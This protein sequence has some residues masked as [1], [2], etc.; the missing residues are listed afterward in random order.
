MQYVGV[1]ALENRILCHSCVRPDSTLCGSASK[2]TV[3]NQP[4]TRIHA[5]TKV[6]PV[7]NVSRAQ[8]PNYMS[9]STASLSLCLHDI[10]RTAAGS[11][12]PSL[13]SA[14]CRIFQALHWE[15]LLGA[16]G[17]VHGRSRDG[18]GC[19]CAPCE[20]TDRLHSVC[21]GGRCHLALDASAPRP[22][23]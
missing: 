20:G 4:G 19:R 10:V 8:C 17:R 6:I 2:S 18:A 9:L 23:P 7:R 1:P 3:N 21:T 12:T 16:A 13:A 22:L 11:T 15:V 5:V 14:A